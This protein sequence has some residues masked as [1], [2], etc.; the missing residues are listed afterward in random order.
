MRTQLLKYILILVLLVSL[1]SASAFA[2][3][4]DPEDPVSP[5]A[6]LTEEEIDAYGGEPLE[7]ESPA[8]ET[9]ADSPADAEPASSDPVTVSAEETF[10]AYEGMSVY[11]NGGTVFNNL[12]TV[13][14][15]GG[16]VYNNGGTVYNNGGAVYANS[17]T[18]YLNAGTVYNHE[19]EVFSRED[20]V[21]S[22]SSRVL[23][24]YELRFAGYY[25]P[26]VVLDGVTVEPGSEQMIITEDSV[27]RLTPR[28]GI[29]I[30]GARTDTGDLYFDETDG[31]IS[32]INVDGDTTLALAILEIT[33]PELEPD[34]GQTA[35]EAVCVVNRGSVP[36]RILSVSLDSEDA[37]AFVL[38][39]T[40]GRTIPAEKADTSTWTVRPS[41]NLEP[42]TYS[43]ELVF[44]LNGGYIGRYP[45]TCTIPADQADDS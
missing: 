35:A 28:P 6:V 20:A 34:G 7:A 21:S 27:C 43:A 41:E 22:G 40:G 5:E 44:T 31:S 38:S 2:E 24:Y 29:L 3:S 33:V 13:Y 18:V 8:P 23:G 14:N 17:G 9:T 12:A 4:A 26:Y 37:E 30:A 42:G 11:N 10:Y 1:L 36:A 15:N 19:A 39:Y 25:E 16:T 32:L 45:L